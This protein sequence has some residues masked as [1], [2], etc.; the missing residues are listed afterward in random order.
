MKIVGV[1]ESVKSQ[2]NLAIYPSTRG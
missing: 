2:L 1:L